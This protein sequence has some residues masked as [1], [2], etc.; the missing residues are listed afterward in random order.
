MPIKKNNNKK[1]AKVN[2]TKQKTKTKA[3]IPSYKTNFRFDYLT[4]RQKPFSQATLENLAQKMIDWVK[5]ETDALTFNEFLILQGLDSETLDDF[6]RRCEKIRL[7]KKYTLMIL[8]TRREKK[9]LHRELEPSVMK[10]MQGFY[11][12][13]WKAQKIFN[14]ELK[15]KM[16]EEKNNKGNVHVHI[17]HYDKLEKEISNESKDKDSS[18]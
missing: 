16:N 6:G 9:A 2:I 1:K 15:A 11:D 10:F 17:D 12:P 4:M 14:A 18:K 13:N 7:A 3:K 5:A 8:G